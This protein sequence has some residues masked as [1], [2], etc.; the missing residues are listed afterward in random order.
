MGSIPVQVATGENI[1]NLTDEEI[2]RCGQNLANFIGFATDGASNTVGCNNSLRSRLKLY[3]LPVCNSNVSFSGPVHS[4]CSIEA[5][6]KYLIF[7]VRNAQVVS[8]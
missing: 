1:F 4:M 8:P 2:K 5:T 7:I 3:L 6:I